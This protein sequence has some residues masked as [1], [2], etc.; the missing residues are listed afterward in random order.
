MEV[1]EPVPEVP[2]YFR[3][4]CLRYETFEEICMRAWQ[5]S[6]LDLRYSQCI[7]AQSLLAIAFY[8]N[9]IT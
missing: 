8:C 7:T 3:R 6:V 9:P 1:V 2:F 5:L 4:I